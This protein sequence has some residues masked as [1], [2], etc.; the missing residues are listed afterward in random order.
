MLLLDLDLRSGD[1][2]SFLDLQPRYTILDVVENFE[3]IDPQYLKDI[4]HGLETGPDVLPGPQ[5]FED[6]ELVQVQHI[7]NI[8]QYI[9][10]QNLYRYLVLDL[11][12]HLDEITLR[13]IERSDIVLLITL[14]TIPG[15][16]DA[17]KMIET[18]QL[19]EINPVKNPPG[20]Q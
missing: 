20:G 18:F 5:R 14:L 11:G 10:S 3:R 15:L 17:K 8:L 6:S 12:D 16:R 1:M 2:C 9:R 13:A 7:D 19:L 4:I